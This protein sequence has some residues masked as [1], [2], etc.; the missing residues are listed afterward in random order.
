M[1]VRNQPRIPKIIH[2]CWFGGKEIPADLQNCIKSW[3]RV[4]GD[5]EFIRWDEKNFDL[6]QNQFAF[7]AS[8]LKKWAFVSDYVRLYAL[9][10]YGGV[11]LDTDVEVLK[12]L[13]PFL[14]H[15]FFSGFESPKQVASSIMG[16]E[17]RN[18]WVNKLLDYYQGKSFLLESGEY[19]EEPNTK[20]ITRLAEERGLELL[21]THQIL[22]GDVHYYPS[23][24]FSPGY[25]SYNR[26][27]PKITENTYTIHYFIG[28]WT[29]KKSESEF[30][31]I[32]RFLKS[33]I[34]VENYIKIKERLGFSKKHSK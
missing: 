12:P 26:R 14:G 2:Y 33:R 28:S 15:S 21:D 20:I 5:Y 32:R 24:F 18:D 34:G 19:H 31:K 3:E 10:N 4:L 1:D 7:E 9:Y 6:T 27:K 11:Y 17:K 16:A 23:E 25:Y 30:K 29:D 22:H 13:D 8:Q